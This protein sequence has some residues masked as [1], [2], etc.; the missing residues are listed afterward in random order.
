MHD[1]PDSACDP[2]RREH[3]ELLSYRE[4][5]RL[6][7][8]PVGTL[9]SLVHQRRI[10]HVRMGARLVRFV[11]PALERWLAERTVGERALTELGHV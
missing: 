6:L 11:R 3:T 8:L 4:A 7:R 1:V 2:Q 9:Y 10:P 5:A